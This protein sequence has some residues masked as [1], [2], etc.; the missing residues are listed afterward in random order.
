[1]FVNQSFGQLRFND[2]LGWQSTSVTTG[3]TTVCGAYSLLGGLPSGLGGSSLLKT[4]EGLPVHK[5]IWVKFTLFLIDQVTGS[6]YKA[7][8]D[9]DGT[10]V[11][12]FTTNIDSNIMNTS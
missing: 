2:S 1:M 10:R 6:D 9:V 3:L 8:V 4:Y 11:L 12:N 7:F 5:K